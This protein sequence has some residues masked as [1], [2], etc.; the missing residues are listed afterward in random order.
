MVLTPV[1]EKPTN[2]LKIFYWDYK[3]YGSFAWPFGSEIQQK[4]TLSQIHGHWNFKLSSVVSFELQKVTDRLTEPV[5]QDPT[6]KKKRNA[7]L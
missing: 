1:C 2:A 5:D 6:Y 4:E 3:N 7:K